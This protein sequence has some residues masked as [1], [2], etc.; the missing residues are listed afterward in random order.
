M[1]P[2]NVHL[3]GAIAHEQVYA[4]MREFTAG[5]IPFRINTLTDFVDPVKF[6]EYRALGL[7][8]LSTKFGEMKFRTEQDGV[9]FLEELDR[10]TPIQSVWDART[11]AAQAA[12]FCLANSWGRR[13]D[14]I[15]SF[16]FPPQPHP[17][18]IDH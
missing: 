18:A 16:I 10:A 17:N 1:L 2:P 14:T 5:I 12:D 13:F 4:A 3:R 15:E 7:P 11:S 8:V 9:F 6:Y